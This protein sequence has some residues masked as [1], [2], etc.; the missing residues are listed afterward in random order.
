MCE[1]HSSQPDVK[2]WID[3]ILAENQELKNK[4]RELQSKLELSQRKYY[5]I[6]DPNDPLEERIYEMITP[7]MREVFT[8]EFHYDIRDGEFA[9]NLFCK[10]VDHFIELVN[11][12]IAFIPGLTTDADGALI[13]KEP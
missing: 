13:F 11:A 10:V 9:G 3:G 12:N 6:V 1:N 7:G 8:H 4:N 5:A 2:A